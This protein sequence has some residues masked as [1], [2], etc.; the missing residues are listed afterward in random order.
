[1]LERVHIPASIGTNLFHRV[2][3]E[4]T[5]LGPLDLGIERANQRAS[6]QIANHSQIVPGGKNHC[7]GRQLGS[8]RQPENPNSHHELRE[9]LT[10]EI[11]ADRLLAIVQRD[12]RIT[13][14]QDCT[15]SLFGFRFI[16]VLV[17]SRWPR[18]QLRSC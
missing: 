8:F 5:Q 15:K 18:V 6:G 3:S 13:V 11:A 17:R 10:E 2:A 7:V 16:L 12:E 9:Q 4:Y 1:L 14:A